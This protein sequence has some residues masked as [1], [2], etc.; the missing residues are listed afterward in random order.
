MKNSAI[1]KDELSI[2]K[3]DMSVVLTDNVHSSTTSNTFSVATGDVLE[4]RTSATAGTPEGLSVY[5][6]FAV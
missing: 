3:E 5:F 6:E 1:L 4:I 2:L